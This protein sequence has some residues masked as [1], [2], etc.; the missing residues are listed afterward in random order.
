MTG[1]V[2]RRG[3]SSSYFEA[4]RKSFGI[5]GIINRTSRR[6]QLDVT[7]PVSLPQTMD[8]LGE[9]WI[10][11]SE[12]HVTLVGPGQRLDD[13]LKAINP[14]LSI[15]KSKLQVE[16]VIGD[17][18]E[19]RTFT[20]IPQ[21]EL[22]IVEEK[23]RKTI[24][25]MCIVEG[26]DE[27]FEQL[28]RWL[29]FPIEVPP[30]HITLY[31]LQN[32]W[33]IGI[34]SR[35]RLDEITR[36]LSNPETHDI[37]RLIGTVDAVSGHNYA[38]GK[39]ARDISEDIMKQTLEETEEDFILIDLCSA[40]PLFAQILRERHK[41]ERCYSQAKKIVGELVQ[42]LE[43]SPKKMPDELKGD[44]NSGTELSDKA[45]SLRNSIVPKNTLLR[46]VITN[47]I[48]D[49]LYEPPAIHGDEPEKQIAE[50]LL[51]LFKVY[52]TVYEDVFE[53]EEK[54]GR[55][56]WQIRTAK[57][58][59]ITPRSEFALIL[60]D[61]ANKFMKGL[62]VFLARKI[63]PN[64][65]RFTA[66]SLDISD[67]EELREE[68][69]RSFPDEFINTEFYRR[70]DELKNHVVADISQ[71]PFP[72]ESVSF[73][74]C[75]EGW[76]FGKFGFDETQVRDMAVWILISLKPGGRALFFPWQVQ[77]ETPQDRKQLELMERL[78]QSMGAKIV[79]K[80]F[81]RNKLKE[82]MVD[83]ELVLV[84]HSPVF[85]EPSDVFTALIL[86]KPNKA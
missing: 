11:K 39:T 66:V 74:T 82:Q 67:P 68:S 33:P 60:D 27:F 3:A 43:T 1:E 21:D 35:Q 57:E 50:K 15:K 58:T 8:V 7:V 42:A 77:H 44:F 46:K 26:A 71:P 41:K 34:Y 84:D 13:R 31:T 6:V 29:G 83:R 37:G 73:F 20:V 30:T 65:R 56:R 45:R 12:F 79:K 49:F 14:H 75:F 61:E 32:G 2:E 48:E 17:V 59:G 23:D 5:E 54:V 64:L 53:L 38:W 16:Q 69:L 62:S 40:F 9:H 28:G 19:G 63:L 10:R 18:S 78:W 80:E 86:E 22:R 70:I 36:K 47:L 25:R 76:P 24:V 72:P 85:Q 55:G 52:S 51:D 81:A 4:R